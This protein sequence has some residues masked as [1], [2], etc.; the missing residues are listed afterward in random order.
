[1]GSRS[2]SIHTCRWVVIVGV[3]IVNTVYDL[4]MKMLHTPAKPEY[5]QCTCLPSVLMMVLEACSST[6]QHLH[7]TDTLMQLKRDV[8]IVS[9]HS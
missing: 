1:M 7:V 2:R 6:K 4:M 8:C 5:R 3:S 9:A